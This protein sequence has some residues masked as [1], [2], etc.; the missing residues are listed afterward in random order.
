MQL[1][2]Q[3]KLCLHHSASSGFN[4][5]MTELVGLEKIFKIIE[6]NCHLH[7]SPCNLDLLW[8]CPNWGRWKKA[9]SLWP[10]C[11][12]MVK[13]K[14]HRKKLETWSV[15]LCLWARPAVDK[16]IHSTGSLLWAVKSLRALEHLEVAAASKPQPVREARGLSKLGKPKKAWNL[17]TVLYWTQD[18]KKQTLLCLKISLKL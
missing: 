2:K 15:P 7:N 17:M 4:L 9:S 13:G 1:L 11:S 18:S 5:W 16:P 10:L 12:V 14:R 3:H 8:D 6:S